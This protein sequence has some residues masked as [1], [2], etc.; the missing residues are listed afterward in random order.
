MYQ[1]EQAKS[2][3][4]VLNISDIRKFFREKELMNERRTNEGMN[5]L[6]NERAPKDE[7]EPV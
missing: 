7:P 5:G 4:K 1:K 2:A 6:T 3:A